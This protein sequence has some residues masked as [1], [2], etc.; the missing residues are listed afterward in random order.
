MSYSAKRV[1]AYLRMKGTES[2]ITDSGGWAAPSPCRHALVRRSACRLV[3]PGGRWHPARVRCRVASQR[4]PRTR[5]DR[6]PLP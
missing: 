6:S 4:V 3:A 5:P 2:L 1:H